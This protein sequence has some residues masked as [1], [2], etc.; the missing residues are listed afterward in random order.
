MQTLSHVLPQLANLSLLMALTIFVYA[1]AGVEL[2]G[3]ITCTEASPCAGFSNHSNFENFFWATITLFRVVTCDDVPALLQ[4]AMKTAPAC[5]DTIG[6]SYGSN[7][8][9]Q[10]A[11]LTAPLYFTSF[12]VV[13][14]LLLLN[15]VIVMMIEQFNS[16][17]EELLL[18]SITAETSQLDDMTEAE[19]LAALGLVESSLDDIALDLQANMSALMLEKQARDVE[20]AQKLE[21]ERGFNKPAEAATNTAAALIANKVKLVSQ[22]SSRKVSA[23]PAAQSDAFMLAPV[24]EDAVGKDGWMKGARE[25][26]SLS[27][28]LTTV[29]EDSTVE[30][31]GEQ[32]TPMAAPSWFPVSSAKVE[33]E[34]EAQ[35]EVE[36][37]EQPAMPLA[38]LDN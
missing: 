27:A 36:T 7:C 25:L 31:E 19:Q 26:M 24:E 3:K 35:L 15:V 30:P 2:F 10:Y 29:T 8:C 13:A 17:T 38:K 23:Q 22:P 20:N 6:C 34:E 18:D 9:V 32:A 28:N 5:D 33:P 4:D 37:A 21:Q 1:C 12:L 11:W 16:A 14:R